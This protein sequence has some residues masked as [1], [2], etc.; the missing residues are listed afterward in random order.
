M[1]QAEYKRP[2]KAGLAPGDISFR[3]VINLIL[4]IPLT[5]LIY[6]LYTERDIYD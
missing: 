3:R 1:G 2:A 4:L 6:R 5:L